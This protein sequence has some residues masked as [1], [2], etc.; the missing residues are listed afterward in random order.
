VED[1]S[2]GDLGVLTMSM[3]TYNNAPFNV[4]LQQ[5]QN[6]VDPSANGYYAASNTVIGL[7]GVI[8]N[9]VQDT[10]SQQ[11]GYGFDI[12]NFNGDSL[13]TIFISKT[14]EGKN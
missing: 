10:R 7:F 3:E 14:L 8:R 1:G 12:A 6:S 5:L 13:F 11:T 2:E 4:V 9:Y